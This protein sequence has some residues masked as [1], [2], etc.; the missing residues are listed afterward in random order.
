MH[1]QDSIQ[2]L[3]VLKGSIDVGVENEVYTLK[4]RE[5]EIINS[6]EV[7]SIKSDDENLVLVL[8]IDPKFFER[9]YEDANEVFFYTD[10]PDKKNPDD[11]KYQILREYISILLYESI[12]KLDDYE[13]QIEENLLKLMY[14]L[15][16]NF[17]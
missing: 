6:N 11:E 2:I 5:I 1:W 3:F 17:H 16:N 14:H 10:S 9:Y 8:Q 7:Y 4:E 15:L 12:S 13:D